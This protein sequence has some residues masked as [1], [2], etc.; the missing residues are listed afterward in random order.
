MVY[1]MLG[2]VLFL[3]LI[4]CIT[5]G[6]LCRRGKKR[7]TSNRRVILTLVMRL[8]EILKKHR[9][10][11]M[12]MQCVRTLSTLDQAVKAPKQPHLEIETCLRSDLRSRPMIK[13][14]SMASLRSVEFLRFKKIKNHL[15]LF[16]AGF[17]CILHLELQSRK[18]WIP[19]TI[20]ICSGGDM[21]VMVRI[22]LCVCVFLL[23]FYVFTAAV[24][25]SG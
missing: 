12:K 16:V 4:I 10:S 23:S 7:V 20:W 11:S 24:C 6:V 18:A 1:V 15:Q 9:V 5:I 21:I 19:M 25:E 8:M 22:C 17:E 2:G 13:R 3:I 14:W